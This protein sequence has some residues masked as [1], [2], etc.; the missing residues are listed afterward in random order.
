MN[1]HENPSN[2][3]FTP[4]DHLIST[5]KVG[6]GLELSLIDHINKDR[7]AKMVLTISDT[8]LLKVTDCL[9]NPEYHNYLNIPKLKHVWVL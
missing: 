3:A 4:A 6:N 2:L 1:L 9:I 7:I 5:R 8:K